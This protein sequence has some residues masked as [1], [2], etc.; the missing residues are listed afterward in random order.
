MKVSASLNLKKISAK[1]SLFLLPLILTANA[2]AESCGDLFAKANLSGNHVSQSIVESVAWDGGEFKQCKEINKRNYC[3]GKKFDKHRIHY[4]FDKND[5][6]WHIEDR[7][8]SME[9]LSCS[10]MSSNQFMEVKTLL[11]RGAVGNTGIPI[12]IREVWKTVYKVDIPAF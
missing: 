8:E 5:T 11:F 6:A 2:R 12:Q 10:R 4:A 1:C 7:R 9:Y 3:G